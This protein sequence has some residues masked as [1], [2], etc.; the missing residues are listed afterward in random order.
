MRA[1]RDCVTL[2]GVNGVAL[3]ISAMNFSWPFP[4]P[5]VLDSNT[6]TPADLRNGCDQVTVEPNINVTQC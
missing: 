1:G 3:K 6:Q 2:C 4:N 5:T